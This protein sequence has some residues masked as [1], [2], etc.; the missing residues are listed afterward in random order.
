MA[1]EREVGGPTSCARHPSVET[2]L[3][4]GRCGTPICPKCLVHTPVGAR[5][6][7]CA[8]PPRALRG[9][10]SPFRT[11]LAALI[12]LGIGM[13]GGVALAFFQFGVLALLPLL[14]TGFLVGEAV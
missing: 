4:C 1:L 5:C 8:A 11:G 9:S 3:R 13:I 7:T 14:L 2:F 10:G 12:G 6:P